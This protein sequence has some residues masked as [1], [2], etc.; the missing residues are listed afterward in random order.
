MQIPELDEATIREQTRSGS[1]ERGKQYF[2]QGAVADVQ[3]KERAVRARVKGSQPMPYVVEIHYDNTGVT[4]A[5]CTCPFHKGAWC[6]HIVATL[7]AILNAT[8]E[9]SSPAVTALLDDLDREALLTLVERLLADHPEL[10]DRVR[11][12]SQR[13]RQ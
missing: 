8:G 2:Q 7:L 3:H 13:L 1:F 10:V 6:K 12:E 5:S 11:S 4:E 9:D